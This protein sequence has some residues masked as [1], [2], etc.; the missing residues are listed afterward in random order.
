MKFWCFEFEGLFSKESVEYP[1]EPFFSSCLVQA[2]NYTDAEYKF[3]EALTERKINLI[4]FGENFPVDTDP[5]EL[6]YENEDNVYW[7]E[8]C[9]EVEISGKPSFQTFCLYPIEELEQKI[10]TGN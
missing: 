3:L 5:N 7:L 2:D 9:E 6:D 1:N 4:E 8:W 10:Q